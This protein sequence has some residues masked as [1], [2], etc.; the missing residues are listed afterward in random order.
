MP[1]GHLVVDHFPL[2]GHGWVC[3]AELS[4]S[5]FCLQIELQVVRQACV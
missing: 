4:M 1:K 2:Q 3:V 5:P